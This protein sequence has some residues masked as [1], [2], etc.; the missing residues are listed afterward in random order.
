[1]RVFKILDTD[2]WQAAQDAG[3]YAGSAADKVDGFIHLSTSAQLVTTLARHF[4]GADNLTLVAIEADALGGALK[5]ELS[6]HGGSYPHVYGD[7]PLS[8]VEWSAVIYKR[9]DGSFVLPPEVF[10]ETAETP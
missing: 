1:M 5:W 2:E 4:A 3:V 8:A 6:S 9:P 10:A 7:L